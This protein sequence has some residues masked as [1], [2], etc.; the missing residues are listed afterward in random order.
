MWE[1]SSRLRRVRRT[2]RERGQLRVLVLRGSVNRRGL[3]RCPGSLW[4]LWHGPHSCAREQSRFALRLEPAQE[5]REAARD[6]L[7]IDGGL[8]QR[9]DRLVEQTEDLRLSVLDHPDCESLCPRSLR[10][11]KSERY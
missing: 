10:S 6:V 11:A 1:W 3:C 2:S 4:H 7:A 5:G 8:V 9:V